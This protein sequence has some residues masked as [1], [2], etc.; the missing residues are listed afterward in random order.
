MKIKRYLLILLLILVFATIINNVSAFSIEK[1]DKYNPIMYV[2]GKSEIPVIIEPDVDLSFAQTKKEL[3]S[4]NKIVLKVNGKTVNTIKKEKS[5]NRYKTYP[6]SLIDRSTKIKGNIKGKKVGIY[7]Y[8]KNNKLL[9]SKVFTVKPNYISKIKIT[10]KNAIEIAKDTGQGGFKITKVV[11][12]K[13]KY[14]IPYYW[15]V[16]FLDSA[17]Y[18]VYINAITGNTI[19]PDVQIL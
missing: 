10:K 6:F 3:N 15:K 16:T 12:K 13:S 2:D 14:D 1:I 11:L 17:Y 9:K 5:W 7:V 19:N 4:I 18:T 8:N